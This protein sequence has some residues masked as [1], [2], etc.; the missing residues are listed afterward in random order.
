[1]SLSY[2]KYNIFRALIL[3]KKKK[4]VWILENFWFWKLLKIFDFENCSKFED[5][6]EK[7]LK[8][9]TDLENDVNK[10]NNS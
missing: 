2:N 8:I 5:I 10:F 7:L 1:M 6:L 3:C 4:N 9:W